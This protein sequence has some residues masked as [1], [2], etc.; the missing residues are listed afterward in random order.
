MA[1]SDCTVWFSGSLSC[2]F[3]F[4]VGILAFGPYLVVFFLGFLFLHGEKH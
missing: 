1:W 2:F 4:F 3:A